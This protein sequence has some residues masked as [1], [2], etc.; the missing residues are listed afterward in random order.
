MT[1]E[2]T[3]QDSAAMPPASTGSGIVA[4]ALCLVV[5]VAGCLPPTPA[6]D[7]VVRVYRPTG[8]LHREYRGRNRGVP[9][10]HN[11]DGAAWVRLGDR[12]IDAAA[13]WQIEVDCE[14]E[15]Q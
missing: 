13:G 2:T 8:E 9:H 12:I 10:V 11:V 1:D 6:V 3:P 4:V 5:V 7:C 15:R 14:A